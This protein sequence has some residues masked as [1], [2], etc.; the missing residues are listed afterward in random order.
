[1]PC[2][3]VSELKCEIEAGTLD[4]DLKKASC[5]IS[6]KKDYSER[7]S[8]DCHRQHFEQMLKNALVGLDDYPTYE[9]VIASAFEFKQQNSYFINDMENITAA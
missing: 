7:F 8:T 2:R 6:S 1:M 5:Y 9:K 4:G 3:Q